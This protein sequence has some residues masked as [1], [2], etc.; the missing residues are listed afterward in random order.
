MARCLQ[1]GRME[2]RTSELEIFPAWDRSLYD[3]AN[4]GQRFS[5]NGVLNVICPNRISPQA[6]ALL[7]FYPAPNI[8]PTG[9]QGY[10]YQTITTAGSNATTA[11]LRYVR[12]FGQKRMGSAGDS[13]GHRAN[14]PT[15][16]RQN[17]NFNGSYSHS[18]R[19]NRNIFLPLGGASR[20]RWLRR[21]GGI[22]DRLWTADQQCF[23]QL[24]SLAH[25]AQELLHRH[26]AIHWLA[27]G[28]VFRNR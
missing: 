24:E 12:N 6:A 1:M 5:C 28:S 14:A 22:H 18:A 10:N 16:L 13:N 8:T 25:D 2:Q 23:D 19:D 4:P 21:H 17:I 11:A 9:R 20:D 27:Q 15:T 26:E 3:P 7:N